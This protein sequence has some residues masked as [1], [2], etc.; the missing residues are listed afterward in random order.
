MQIATRHALYVCLFNCLMKKK[1]EA[2][3]LSGSVSVL[4]CVVKERDL[5]I[6]KAECLCVGGPLVCVCVFF[7]FFFCKVSLDDQHFIIF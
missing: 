2:A 3:T 4:E 6:V 1:C 5:G 7:F